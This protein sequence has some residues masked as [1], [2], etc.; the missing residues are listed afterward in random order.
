MSFQ[1]TAYFHSVLKQRLRSV[2][3]KSVAI[4]SRP[5]DPNTPLKSPSSAS[6]KPPKQSLISCDFHPPPSSPCKI[7]YPPASSATQLAA[8]LAV[9]PSAGAA[10]PSPSPLPPP[11]PPSTQK[12]KL[13]S[14]KTLSNN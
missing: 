14:R 12:P 8:L 10:D 6:S 11:L 7:L 13:N 1:K 4:S 9:L 3:C 5:Q 2:C